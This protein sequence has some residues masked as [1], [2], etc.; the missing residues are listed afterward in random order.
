MSLSAREERRFA[1]FSLLEPGVARFRI[2]LFLEVSER[3]IC[4]Y[5]VRFD[6]L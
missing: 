6:Q 2:T 1:A 5:Q 3:T 4:N